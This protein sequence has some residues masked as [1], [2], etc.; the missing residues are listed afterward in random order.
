MIAGHRSEV[1]LGAGGCDTHRVALA[2][3]R[4][5]V[6]GNC[7]RRSR[8]GVE[9]VCMRERGQ[10]EVEL[11]IGPDRLSLSA[12]SHA[13]A[14]G[15]SPGRS[16]EP[17]HAGRPLSRITT[18]CPGGRRDQACAGRSL[19]RL[20]RPGRGIELAK[21]DGDRLVPTMKRE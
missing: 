3:Y 20:W 2:V 13:G 7:D 8:L 12:T 18:A 14:R 4:P 19:S 11:S 15:A 9:V 6:S 17:A 16:R 10:K 21:R 5:V 1:M